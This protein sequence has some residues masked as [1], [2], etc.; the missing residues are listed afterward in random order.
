MFT[1]AV[2]DVDVVI[3][4]KQRLLFDRNHLYA[5]LNLL[6]YIPDTDM[7]TQLEH[8]KADLESR[9]DRLATEIVEMGS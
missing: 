4:E 6:G 5:R 3:A 9:I 2:R 8:I 1:T 7:R